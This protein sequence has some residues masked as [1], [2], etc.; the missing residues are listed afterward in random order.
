LHLGKRIIPVLCRPLESTIVP[1]ELAGLNYIFFYAEPKSPGSGFGTGLL[2]LVSALNTDLDWLREHTRLLQRASEWEA[3]GRTESRML[4]GDSLAA[5]KLWVGRRPKEA[6]EPTTL[7]Y[8]FIRA[9]EEAEVR[10]QN[11]ERQRLEERE[12]LIKEAEVAQARTARLQRVRTWALAAVGIAVAI[13]VGA[14]SWQQVRLTAGP[15]QLVSNQ[16]ELQHQQANLLAQLASVEWLRGNMDRALR[17]STEGA[18]SDLAL[19]PGT[20][21][22]SPVAAQLAATLSLT[23]WHLVLRHDSYVYF[24]AFSPDGTRVVTASWD[25]TARIWDAATGTEL[26]VLHGHEA[27]VYSAAF[28]P[29]GNRIVTA[30][31]D[32][33]ARIWDAATGSEIKV[34]RGHE[35]SVNFATFS[36]D[37]TRI[38]TA[39]GSRTSRPL[40]NQHRTHAESRSVANDPLRPCPAASQ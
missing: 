14:T 36:P 29:D 21:I 33:T 25:K 23:D 18:R 9:S 31:F 19:P 7:H 10:Q 1:P 11:A 26:K 34:L 20:V 28:S 30:S 5:A 16:R 12:R 6:P 13:G 24:A 35:E 17:F 27:N 38:V 2:Q 4:F 40:S 22:A 8:D 37:G 15:R 32:K 39:S 3:A